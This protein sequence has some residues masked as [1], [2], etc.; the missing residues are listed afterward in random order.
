M[1]RRPA[2]RPTWPCGVPRTTRKAAQPQA[3]GA[4]HWVRLSWQL[5]LLAQPGGRMEAQANQTSREKEGVTG[6]TVT[7]RIESRFNV[8]DEERWAWRQLPSGRSL[9]VSSE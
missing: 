8:T 1:W 3:A 6:F 9:R 7:M 2:R 5:G 4:A